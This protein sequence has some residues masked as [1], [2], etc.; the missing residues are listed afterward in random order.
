MNDQ[1]SGV[2]AIV[3]AAGASRRFGAF[4]QLWPWGRGTMLSTV[5]D[6]ALASPARPVVVVLGHRAADCRAA[7]GD[8][9]VTVVINTAWEEGQSTSVR[10]GLSALPNDVSAALFL[11]ADQPAIRVDT[12][13]AVIRCY[14]VTRAPVVWPEVDGRRGNPVLFDRSLFAE[15]CALRGDVGGRLVLDAHRDIAARV[16]VIDRAVLLD[17]DT[18][19]DIS[20][21]K[22][23]V[24]PDA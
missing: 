23:P 11:L 9:L 2:A 4:K 24:A 1:A 15:L 17:I 8:R 21:N 3:L 13:E 5:V 10:A 12:L 16:A 18:P 20:E 22:T 14:H 19:A 6:T 7:L